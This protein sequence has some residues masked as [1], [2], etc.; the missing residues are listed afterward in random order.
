MII[1]LDKKF[2]PRKIQGVFLLIPVM[3][4]SISSLPI[5]VNSTAYFI[6]KQFESQNSDDEVINAIKSM[7][8][9]FSLDDELYVRNYIKELIKKGI[10][11][12][13]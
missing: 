6:L 7:Y 1:L 10:L 11:N 3:K 4:N 13:V 5:L 8:K 12:E 2:V 9:D